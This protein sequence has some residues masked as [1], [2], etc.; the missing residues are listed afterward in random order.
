MTYEIR[1]MSFGE[2][3]DM[4]FRILRNHF[5][6]LISLSAVMYVPLAIATSW[7]TSDPTAGLAIGA[8]LIVVLAFVVA[9]PIVFA[10]IIFAVGEAYVGRPV[11][12][13]KSLRS[14]TPI[15]GPL[16]GT[17]VLAAVYVIG[18]YL[19]L[20]VPGIYLQLCYIVAWQVMVIERI[21][22]GRALARSRELMRG[23]LLRGAGVLFIGGLVVGI[24]SQLLQLLLAAVPILGPIGSGLAQAAGAA[25]TSAITVVLYFDIRCRKEAF[26]LEHLARLV[27]AKTETT[28]F[29]A[30]PS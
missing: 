21:F 7:F 24:S 10:A 22:G 8:L 23:N 9:S 13:G 28:A 25:Y 26:D 15:I 29:A 5:V 27:E 12:F 4:G 3:L 6:P 11:E 14:V 1:P 17:T 30:S 20:I 19:L 16:I 18:G 2:I